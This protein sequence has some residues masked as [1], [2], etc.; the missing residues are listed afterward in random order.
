MVETVTLMNGTKFVVPDGYYIDVI[1][2]DIYDE[3][4]GEIKSIPFLS[5]NND[6]DDTPDENVRERLYR[7]SNV[8]SFGSEIDG[9]P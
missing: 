5:I 1:G 2:S 3:E 8:I 4:T 9:C 6:D 7:L